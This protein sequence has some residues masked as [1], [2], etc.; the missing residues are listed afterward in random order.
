VEEF[1]KTLLLTASFLLSASGAWAAACELRTSGTSYRIVVDG[2]WFGEW[3][4]FRNNEGLR[5]L[6]ETMKNLVAAGM[7]SPFSSISSTDVLSGKLETQAPT[8]S[9]SGGAND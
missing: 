9:S 3:V 8:T 4:D 7:C 2:H 1:M 5:G 6:S